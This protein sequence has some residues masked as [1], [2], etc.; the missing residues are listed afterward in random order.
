TNLIDWDGDRLDDFLVVRRGAVNE[1]GDGR[2]YLHW[3]IALSAYGGGIIDHVFG[4]SGDRVFSFFSDGRPHMGAVRIGTSGECIGQ[5]EWWSMNFSLNVSERQIV[6]RCWGLPGD[7]PIVR[8]DLNNNG[9]ADWIVVRPEGHAQ[10]AYILYDNQ[11]EW[12]TRAL[13]LSNAVPQV[14]NFMGEGNTFGWCQR[15]QGLV[16]LRRLDGTDAI[17][18]FG[19]A[20]NAIIRPDGTVVQSNA[21]DRLTSQPEPTPTPINPPP[22]G[23]PTFG[24]GELWK[25]AGETRGGVPVFL[26]SDDYAGIPNS[27]IRIEDQNGNLVPGFRVVD[28][29]CC[30]NGGR[31]HFWVAPKCGQIPANSIVRFG[32][33]CRSLP[34]P[35]RRYE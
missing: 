11:Q 12:T 33:Q 35:C 2:S 18:P 9:L 29:T 5:L 24:R 16:G 34:S 13:G 27:S 14:G 25:P 8:T 19:I 6:K 22:S 21:S 15:D 1:F 28:R 17:L 10:I 4:Q 31:A 20:T 26:V 7:I 3:F 30:P 32:N 23:C